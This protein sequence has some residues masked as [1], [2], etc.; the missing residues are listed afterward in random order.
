VGI[1][2]PTLQTPSQI[3]AT[4]HGRPTEAVSEQGLIF[5]V[6]PAACAEKPC[7]F[8]IVQTEG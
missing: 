6:L 8:E 3:R 1:G 2:L 5:V 7:P 4:I